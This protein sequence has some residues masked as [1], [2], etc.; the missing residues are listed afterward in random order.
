VAEPVRALGLSARQFLVRIHLLAVQSQELREILCLRKR[1]ID[2]PLIS[3]LLFVEARAALC[4]TQRDVTEAAQ[5]Q[6]RHDETD[7]E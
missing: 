3:L 7:A 2:A 1:L 5:T 4:A 6:G